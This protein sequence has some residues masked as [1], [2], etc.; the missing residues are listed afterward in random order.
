MTTYDENRIILGAKDELQILDGKGNIS[1]LSTEHKGRIII[2]LSNNDIV[3]E[4]QD[5]FIKLWKIDN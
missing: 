3:T 1:P 5:K 2:K 4:G